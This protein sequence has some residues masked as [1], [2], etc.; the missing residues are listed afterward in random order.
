MSKEYKTGQINN[1]ETL[2]SSG[3]VFSLADIRP[4]IITYGERRPYTITEFQ[5]NLGNTP[6]ICLEEQGP[7]R[8]LAKFEGANPTGSVKARTAYALLEDAIKSG[9]L[10]P[11]KGIVIGSGGNFAIAL[12]ALCKPLGIPLTVALLSSAPKP[13][14]DTIS[15]FGAQIINDAQTRDERRSITDQ[16][17]QDG[18]YFADQHNSPTALLAMAKS[19]GPEIRSQTQDK[20]TDIVAGFGTG[21]TAL[22]LGLYFK[23]RY[24]EGSI[25]N[26][27]SITA[28]ED[29]LSVLDFHIASLPYVNASREVRERFLAEYQG[30]TG[31]KMRA[32]RTKNGA[33]SKVVFD[34]AERAVDDIPGIG[35]SGLQPAV[36]ELLP[37]G[38]ITQVA[39][40]VPEKAYR[41]TRQLLRRKNLYVGISSGAAYVA[42]IKKF[43]ENCT[44]GKPGDVVAIFPDA[45]GLYNDLLYK[46]RDG[47]PDIFDDHF[48]F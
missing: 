35:I 36:Q 16:L 15:S 34:I 17:Q 31:R 40:V 14:S 5:A 25:P 27:V 12:A 45:G 23:K 19:L 39:K 42:A 11:D 37:M 29:D 13:F 1:Q 21:M 32:Y 3:T 38:L 43:N 46:D 10:S 20:V 8:L 47:V 33:I 7:N 22:G 6:M 2:R 28:V 30:S 44:I 48:P 41:A 18:Y 24:I 26:P 4:G 9:Q